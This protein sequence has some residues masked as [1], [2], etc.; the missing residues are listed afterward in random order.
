MNKKRI[1]HTTYGSVRHA[2]R[3]MHE[4]QSGADNDYEVSVIGAPREPFDPQLTT[5]TINGM[6][7]YLIPLLT[8]THPRDLFQ[9][10]R[11]WLSADLGHHTTPMPHGRNKL[12]TGLNILLYNLWLLRLAMRLKP[13]LIHCHELWGLPASLLLATFRRI[14]IIYDVW[15]PH[16]LQYTSQWKNRLI[17]AIERFLSRRANAVITASGRMKSYFQDIGANDVEYIGNWKRLSDYDSIESSQLD[18]LRQ[19]L[20]IPQ[21]TLVVSYIGLL[22]ETR[23]ILPLLQAMELVHDVVLIIGGRGSHRSQ[24]IE[25]A[26]K[27]P[28]IR[29][30]DWVDLGDVPLY[31]RLADVIYCCLADTPMAHVVVANKMFETFLAGKVM[32]ATKG[33][34][35]MS[36]VLEDTQTGY[37]I[38][39]VTPEVIAQALRTLKDRELLKQYKQNSLAVRDAYA[40]SH[41][42]QLLL[43]LYQRL[44]S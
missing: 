2:P 42:E 32:L 15:D 24:V 19:E 22:F 26:E 33:L 18:E 37:L 23:E 7:T 28:N 10:F 34:G 30:L 16:F 41:G 36:D 25:A 5:D 43:S 12:R 31:T 9:A 1:L 20:K 40:W 13:D 8:T 27:L 21:D 35:E 44:L 39:E 6:A 4:G 3:V 17:G 14:P 11:A 38:D 29:W